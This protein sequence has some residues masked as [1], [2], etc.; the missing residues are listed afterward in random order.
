[1]KKLL[2]FFLSISFGLTAQNNLH[3]SEQLIN[4][5]IRIEAYNKIDSIS[6]GTGFFYTIKNDSLKYEIPLIITNKHIIN[7]FKNIRLYF[8]TLKDNK[9]NN[10]KSQS[11]TIPNDTT[12]VY[13]HP[14][15]KIDLV[16]I[17]IMN[18]LSESKKRGVDLSYI[19]MDKKSIPTDSIQKN[20]LKSIEDV[21]MIGYPNGLWDIKNNLPIVRKGITATTPYLDFN[22][23]RV[24]LIDIAAFNGSSG[25]PIYFYRDIYTDKNYTPKI[26]LKL[27]LLGILYAGPQF[28][29]K[30]EITKINEIDFRNSSEVKT[31]IPMNIGYV[32]KASEI[33]E[34]EKVFYDKVMNN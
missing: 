20:E 10:D 1:M 34:F 21:L 6:S 8:K 33:F 18:M 25:S 7:G 13:E 19:T 11:I 4:T 24:F 17:P 16:A 30:G 32:I 29:V 12:Y 26:G 3:I 27:Y 23:E 31:K 2:I 9:P 22:G 14:N 5:T 28:S 15:K